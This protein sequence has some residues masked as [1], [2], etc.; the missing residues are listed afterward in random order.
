MKG[1]SLISLVMSACLC[2][3]ATE[4]ATA[5]YE[6]VFTNIGAEN[7]GMFPNGRL[8]QGSDGNFYGTSQQGGV[9]L[10]GTAFRLTPGGK[11]SSIY[12]FDSGFSDIGAAPYAAF[13]VGT[14]RNL[15]RTTT[16]RSCNQAGCIFKMAL[17][18]QPTFLQCNNLG[19]A[20]V[21]VSFTQFMRARDGTFYTAS[22]DL[23]S[24]T[25]YQ[26]GV[27]YHL[28][29]D[30]SVL[31]STRMDRTAHGAEPKAPLTEGADGNIY[32]V[33]SQGGINELG[34]MFRV[35]PAG[36]ITLLHPFA[37]SDGSK[38]ESALIQ[39]SDGNFY[40]TT[41][42]GGKYDMGT[43]FR[44]T[45]TGMV[46]TLVS[47]N[48]ANGSY[49]AGGLTVGPN[50]LLYGT[51]NGGGQTNDGTFYQ[52]TLQGSLITLASF[53]SASTGR[54]PSNGVTLGR[55]G[56]FYGTTVAEG[57]YGYG[58]AYRATPAGVLTR[59]APLG[60][61]EGYYPAN[62][63]IEGKDGNL[64]GSTS[65]GGKNYAGTIFKLAPNGKLFTLA[66]L[67]QTTTGY[68]PTP[69]VQGADGNFYGATN[70]G[71]SNSVGAIFKATR[72]GALTVVAPLN[73]TTGYN[74]FDF[75]LGQ[76]GNFYI[77]TGAGSPNFGGTI[78]RLS[79]GGV[80]S[81]L[82][83]LTT[84]AS[85]GGYFRF[86]QDADL[87]FYG[88]SSEGGT[89]NVGVAFKVNTAGVQTTLSNFALFD[90]GEEPA[91]GLTRGLNGN[92]Y[93]TTLFGGSVSGNGVVFRLTPT[94]VLSVVHNFTAIEANGSAGR[95]LRMADGS[96]LGTTF[97][98]IN[99]GAPGLLFR[100][101][102]GGLFE[103]WPVFDGIHGSSPKGGLILASDGYIYGTTEQGG[104]VDGGVVFRFTT[105]PPQVS[106]F[107][108]TSAQ[109]GHTVV[110]TG[111]Y[112]AGT[113]SVSFNGTT[114]AK[115]TIDSSGQITV[116][117][118]KGATTG[119]I[120]ITNPIGTAST[121]TFTVL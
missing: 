92:F 10:G 39:A 40:G 49:P 32:G 56:K 24:S 116:T 44:A 21:P 12:P 27:I 67:D 94:G 36:V 45:T 100:V 4:G 78:L 34:T 29:V 87:N 25:P 66:S 113:S 89:H 20:A 61:P 97:Q 107:S 93:G 64:Y 1:V 3:S 71:G 101:T 46:T 47:F 76:D 13:C 37:G 54:V 11:V 43:V 62:G 8:V 38:P 35:S 106:Q 57:G 115:F 16:K 48:G 17:S 42:R 82:A 121:A 59:L 95:L 50:G 80:L 90:Q 22:Y 84:G 5:L 91:G 63:V 111:R 73:T 69:I 52:V 53:N 51:T 83:A 33:A 58:T 88:T 6:E 9:K 104:I 2:A 26:V 119:P 30:G 23:D 96:F 15:Y 102:T 81:R 70:S 19:P 14:D 117:V 86:M 28:N 118:P 65:L 41:T 60:D 114:A 68:N 74:A 109:P 79:S 77:L 75:L 18:G 55:D 99:N 112:L 110:L 98:N 85:A 31:F 7:T 103:K 108:P 72:A 120:T 105:S